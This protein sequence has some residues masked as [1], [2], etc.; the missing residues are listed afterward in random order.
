[1]INQR[2]K[3]VILWLVR[4]L[5]TIACF[6]VMA[7]IFSNSLTSGE[8]SSAQSSQITEEVK[9]A[10]E[11]I[12]PDVSF[13]GATEEEDF[14]ILHNYVRDFAHF[15]EFALLGA[16][17]TWCVRSYTNKKPFFI[18]PVPFC[19]G[20]AFFDEYLQ[21]FSEGRAWQLSDVF[22]D[23]FGALSGFVFAVCVIVL[24]G[25]II[26]KRNERLIQ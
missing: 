2:Q 12:K 13:G 17:C 23:S 5:L 8:Q 6:V 21:K 15:L 24:V 4:I 16:L 25:V 20:V 1:M 10:I 14:D 9:D 26:K 18:I 11:T 3:N 7:W 22:T 19:V